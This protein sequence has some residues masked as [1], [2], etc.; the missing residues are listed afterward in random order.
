MDICHKLLFIIFSNGDIHV[1]AEKNTETGNFGN[2]IQI[3]NV[4][5]MHPH[6][7]R[8]KH[9]RQLLQ[10]VQRNDRLRPV[11][12][13]N[14]HILT[15]LLYIQ[16]FLFVNAYYLVFAFHNS[17][18]FSSSGSAVLCVSPY[19]CRAFSAALRHS[20]KLKGFIR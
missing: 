12:H 18:L 4:R 7:V 5:T 6:K 13:L 19:I 11:F 17:V 16:D 20:A 1:F 10:A 14:T 3:D 8:R 9:G 15:H 2:F